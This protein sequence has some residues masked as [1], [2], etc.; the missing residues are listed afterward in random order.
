MHAVH[1]RD[2]ESDFRCRCVDIVRRYPN[3][4]GACR[5]VREMHF[6]IAAVRDRLIARVPGGCEQLN[7]RRRFEWALVILGEPD[8]QFGASAG[9]D[10]RRT[11]ALG[12]NWSRSRR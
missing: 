5:N 11:A 2:G 8:D 6:I 3:R 12:M 4:I 7:T 1:W 10:R 9:T